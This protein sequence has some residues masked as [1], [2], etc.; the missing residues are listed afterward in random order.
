MNDVEKRKVQLD[1]EIDTNVHESGQNRFQKLIELA[2]A[3]DAWRIFPR[4]FITVY[5]YLLYEVVIWF[6]SLEA[7]TTQQAGLISIMTGV[8]AAW[9][10]L[11]TKTKGDG[12]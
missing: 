12:N 9:F 11:Y 6:M 2:E 8:G 4:A 7:P 5:I 3:V 10:G 1:I